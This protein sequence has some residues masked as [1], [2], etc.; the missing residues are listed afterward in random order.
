MPDD[1]KTCPN[2]EEAKETLSHV[3]LFLGEL[4]D[5]ITMVSIQRN[6]VKLFIPHT[7]SRIQFTSSLPKA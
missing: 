5:G 1:S 3:A 6:N 7:Y 2:K 4:R